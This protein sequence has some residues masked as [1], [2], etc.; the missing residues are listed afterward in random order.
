[1]IVLLH[2][3]NFHA[4]SRREIAHLKRVRAR[5]NAEFLTLTEK[6][7]L[8][9]ADARRLNTV[10]RQLMLLVE[11]QGVGMPEIIG[12]ARENEEILEEMRVSFDASSRGMFDF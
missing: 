4:A 1:M 2:W 7:E 10:E 11:G 8:M 5:L 9:R 3:T 12:L 6:T